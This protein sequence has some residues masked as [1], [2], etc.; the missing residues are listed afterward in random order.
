M[1]GAVPFEGLNASA[2]VGRRRPAGL[3]AA[4]TPRHAGAAALWQGPLG[5]ELSER[6]AAA[7]DGS[8]DRGRHL[9]TAV[10]Q[11]LAWASAQPEIPRRADALLK[12]ST[13]ARWAAVRRRQGQAEG[14]VAT[15]LARLRMLAG[16]DGGAA[17]P[18]AAEPPTRRWAADPTSTGSGLDPCRRTPRLRGCPHVRRPSRDTTVN[19]STIP[20]Y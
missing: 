11:L 6:I 5:G 16:H 14:S 18:P 17:P 3:L 13:L 19:R 10:A 9:L 12:E 1:G 15:N 20:T 2:M 8:A 4:F 7:A